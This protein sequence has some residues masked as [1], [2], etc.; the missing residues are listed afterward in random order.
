MTT[1]RPHASYEN[2]VDQGRLFRAT[3]RLLARTD[4]LSFPDYH[5]KTALA[6]DIN[7]FFVRKITRIRADIDATEV[8]DTVPT[9]SGVGDL[10]TC[11]S[12]S[13]FCPL[14]ESDVSALIKKSAK[15]SCLMDPMPTSLVV[16]CLDV[17][18]P[19]ITRI[20]NS[21]LPSGYFPAEWKE[22]LVCPLLKKA[23]LDPVFKNLRPVSNLQFLSKLTERAV[24]DQTYDRMMDVGLYPLFQS[25]YRKGHSTETALL[26]VQNDILMNMNRQHVTLLVLLDLSVAFDTVDHKILLHRLHSSLGITG[27]ALKWFELYLSYRSQRVFSGGCLSDS[28]KLPYGVPQGSCLGPLLFT[29]Y[30]SKS[31]DVFLLSNVLVLYQS[32][33]AKSPALGP[34]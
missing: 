31:F 2:S 34:K 18:L 8:D 21:S 3:K 22:A 30:S 6:Y 10:C 33:R 13:S 7:D 24:F 26:K 12:L 4:E 1:T 5:E 23:G 19:V 25:A 17:L 15:K 16:G 32:S 9:E 28:I 20:V 14:T 27:T 29:I 11:L